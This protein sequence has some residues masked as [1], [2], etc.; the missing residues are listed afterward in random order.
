MKKV[1][2]INAD[3]GVK[4]SELDQAFDVAEHLAHSGGMGWVWFLLRPE[5]GLPGANGWGINRSVAL[6][7]CKVRL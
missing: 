3:G 7:C 6:H 5:K 1:G 4:R 2:F